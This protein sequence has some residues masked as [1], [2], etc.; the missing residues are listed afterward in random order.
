[1]VLFAEI[2]FWKV[3]LTHRH[4]DLFE[5]AMKTIECYMIWELTVYTPYSCLIFQH[6]VMY[7]THSP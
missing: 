2:I 4:L 3:L 5:L 6:K 7:N 1:M